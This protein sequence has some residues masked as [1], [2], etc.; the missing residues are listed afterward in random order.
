MERPNNQNTLI[1]IFIVVLGI[2]AGYLYYSKFHT[3]LAVEPLS[4]DE[5]ASFQKLK[6]LTIDFDLLQN[7]SFKS[8]EING[9]FPVSGATTGKSDPFTP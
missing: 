9:E 8:L 2:A 3:A 5:Q 1:A 4:A 7:P 6:D